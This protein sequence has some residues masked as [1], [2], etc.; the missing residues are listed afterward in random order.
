MNIHI[1]DSILTHCLAQSHLILAFRPVN[2]LICKFLLSIF[3]SISYLL[4]TS[5]G[6]DLQEQHLLFSP[7]ASQ[8]HTLMNHA[9]LTIFLQIS[10][11]FKEAQH[12]KFNIQREH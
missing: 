3:L 8:L 4:I 11:N 9:G 1:L 10:S 2:C 5:I 7:A 6:Y 12:K